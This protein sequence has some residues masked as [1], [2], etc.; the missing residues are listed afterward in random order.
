[1]DTISILAAG[2][3]QAR[4]Q[5]LDMLANNLA[6][7]E[8]GG[9]KAD[10]ER[11]SLFISPDASAD[12]V[13]GADTTLPL[14]ES[15]WTDT[16]QGVLRDTFN[17][18]DVAIDGSGMFA[19]QTPQGVRYTRNGN[20]RVNAKG[21]LAANDGNPVLARNGKTIALQPGLPVD[22]DQ[23]GSIQQGGQQI[24]QIETVQFD[25]GNLAKTGLNYF[26]PLNGATSKPASGKIVQGKLEQ[27]NVGSAESAVRLIAIMR[28]FEM[29]QKAMTIAGE[30][31]QKAIQEVAR[32]AT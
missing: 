6:N 4:M 2:G 31:N 17:P 25:P 13:T 14:I 8:T 12:P 26:I 11:F 1:M 32:V 21:A 15:T 7:V 24:A 9:Y 29:L 18:L 16:S 22:V 10:K 28:Q 3:M 23:N 20:F 30:L 19:I 27:S 5:S